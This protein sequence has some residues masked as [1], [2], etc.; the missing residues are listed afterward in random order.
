[1]SSENL[2][3]PLCGSDCLK[4]EESFAKCLKCDLHFKFPDQRVSQNEEKHRY[5]LHN[6]SVKDLGY[7]NYLKRLLECIPSLEEPILDFGCGPTKGLEALLKTLGKNEQIDS[8][9]PYFFPKDLELN[10]YKTV[11]ASECFEHFNK[12]HKSISKIKSLMADNS[13]LAIR[14]EIYTNEVGPLPDWWYFK[15][16]THVCFY[17]VKSITWI[18]NEFN[19][20]VLLIDSPFIILG[21]V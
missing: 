9:D 15:D 1:M 5:S 7:L 11:Y 19:F 17:T 3:C 10:H 2:E 8:Y 16:P 14:T 12:P 18:A 20:K 4:V 6:N 21:V 13:T